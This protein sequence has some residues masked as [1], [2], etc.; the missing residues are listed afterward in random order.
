MKKF[1]FLLTVCVVSISLTCAFAEDST[2]GAFQ[3]EM[4]DW[5]QQGGFTT[6]DWADGSGFSMPSLGEG[7][8]WP[9]GWGSFGDND[10]SSFFSNPSFGNWG[11]MGGLSNMEDWEK[12]FNDFQNSLGSDMSMDEQMEAFRQQMQ[13]INGNDATQNGQFGTQGMEDIKSLFQQSHGDVNNGG[14]TA[15]V[16]PDLPVTAEQFSQSMRARVGSSGNTAYSSSALNNISQIYSRLSN[17]AADASNSQMAEFTMEQPATSMSPSEFYEQNT[18]KL[19]GQK[20]T[21]RI[22]NIYSNQTAGWSNSPSTQAPSLEMSATEQAMRDKMQGV[23]FKYQLPEQYSDASRV[24]FANKN[25]EQFGSYKSGARGI[26]S[27]FLNAQ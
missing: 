18:P 17:T 16:M 21:Q 11:D 25:A 2:W 8:S 13:G 20:A 3:F 24:A 19:G 27:D 12:K 10:G 4:P 15:A 26:V 22:K 7:L 9:E 5:A 6:P 1:L 14:L 23:E